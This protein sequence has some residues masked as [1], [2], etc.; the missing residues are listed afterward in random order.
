M[1]TQDR[2]DDPASFLQ[3]GR[4]RPDG[5]IE[6]S[7]QITR[8]ADPG[9]TPFP[10]QSEFS[11]NKGAAYLKQSCAQ[12]PKPR[13]AQTEQPSGFLRT[14]SPRIPEQRSLN[15]QTKT[16]LHTGGPSV[17]VAILFSTAN[18]PFAGQR[19]GHVIND[20]LCLPLRSARR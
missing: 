17:L 11:K 15:R 1:Q 20:L 6:V 4:F 13:L 7:G 2:A 16:S 3:L 10:D 8:V 19:I 9:S 14:N 12:C 5:G 18:I